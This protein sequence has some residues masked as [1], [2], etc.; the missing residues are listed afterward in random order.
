MRRLTFTAFIALLLAAIACNMPG[1]RSGSQ[2]EA[3]APPLPTPQAT[4][5]AS[6]AATTPETPQGAGSDASV[7]SG[8][9]VTEPAP[10]GPPQRGEMIYE[11]DLRT[12]WPVLNTENGTGEP[13]PGGYRITLPGGEAW[14]LWA[15]T[16]RVNE[17]E[18][19]AEITAAPIQCPPGQ[20]AY[21]LIFQHRDEGNLRIFAVTCSGNYLLLERNG[22]ADITL[23]EGPLPEGINPATGEHLISVRAFNNTVTAYVDGRE[24]TSASVPGMESGDIG[25]Y[26]QTGGGAISIMFTRLAIYAPE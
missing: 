21:G 11:S 16:S 15:F 22:G 26:V 13:L 18:F 1:F 25:P 17:R 12:G 24:I 7:P 10:D 23:A 19:L 6:G 20:G 4:P 5:A 8:Q 14:A 9:A 3:T 2:P